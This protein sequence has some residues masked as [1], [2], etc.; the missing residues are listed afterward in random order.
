MEGG[1]TVKGLLA[2]FRF[3]LRMFR[4]NPK[5]VLVALFSLALG[6]GINSIIFGL[7]DALILR[8]FPFK[9]PDRV[10]RLSINDGRGNLRGGFCYDDYLEL[11]KY[12]RTLADVTA[13]QRGGVAIRN[14]GGVE[15]FLAQ[16]VSAGYFSLLT[17]RPRL[18]R[19]FSPDDANKSVLVIGHS[20]W[21]T[22]FGSDPGVIGRRVSLYD[23]DATIIGV[24]PQE[25]TGT[26]RIITS[27]FWQPLESS[28]NWNDVNRRRH[29][30]LDIQARLA[31]GVTLE[32]CRA[33]MAALSHLLTVRP[34]KGVG[35][36]KITIIPESDY[37]GIGEGGA[38]GKRLAYILMVLTGIVLLIAC[39]NVSALFFAKFEER[40][41]EIAIRFALGAGRGRL[42][43]LLM[44]ESL[45]LALAGAGLCLVISFWVIDGTR[46]FIPSLPFS[47]DPGFR[48]DFRVAGFTLL[49]SV[50]SMLV[51]G[52]APTLRCSK[53]D[54]TPVMKGDTVR[55]STSRLWLRSGV[56]V[57]QLAVSLVLLITSSILVLGFLRGL[58]A[59]VGFEKKDMLLITLDSGGS[60]ETML[61]H[62]RQL[63]ENIQSLPGAKGVTWAKAAPLAL[64]GT[65]ARQSVYFSA[66]EPTDQANQIRSNVV[67]SDYFRL[68]GIRIIQG[69]EF[70]EQDTASSRKVVV[71]SQAMAA[72]FW[73][74][75]SAIG[76]TIHIGESRVASEIV[77]I[78]ADVMS[79]GMRVKPEAYLYLAGDQNPC[80]EFTLM[81]D[82]I[83]SS[84]QLAEEIRKMVRTV[85]PRAVIIQTTSL[86]DNL[87]FALLPNQIAAG[88]FGSFGVLALILA[89]IGLYGVVSL[90][91]KQRTA[92]IGIRLA[93]GAQP[94]QILILTMRRGG[95]LALLGSVIGV[96]IALPIPSGLAG[97][98]YGTQSATV[99]AYL[100]CVGLLLG[101]ILMANFVPAFR[102]SRMAPIRALRYE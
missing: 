69:R 52:L 84:G 73:P 8:P 15:I 7:V 87:R 77:G 71:I 16:E 30:G 47:L 34:Q 75:R 83:S 2:D 37:T 57:G 29:P 70:S 82:G 48:M 102:A 81:V 19:F 101:V 74:G 25:F 60:K 99:P 58:K 88:V 68:M 62:S 80:R 35:Q 36:P 89:T 32:Q 95:F 90:T 10:V 21:A 18:G 78:A 13:S 50:L 5:F 53:I 49:I 66:D 6:I 92:E 17:V 72:R 96:A 38:E 54:L 3:A 42:I 91:I 44:I 39:L 27:D 33:E 4:K 23:R 64:S 46:L 93:L 14:E 56:I 97:D 22:R 11:G 51:F 65:G 28:T 85:T 59:D 40:R 63:V 20:V 31:P 67:A 98:F 61:S 55:T 1:K 41:R 100:L 79:Q 26:E 12:A 76:R 45:M 43:R 24:A 94:G 9:E 86:K